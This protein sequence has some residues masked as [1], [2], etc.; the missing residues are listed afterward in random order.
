MAQID[1]RATEIS[2]SPASPPGL[3]TARRLIVLYPA[4]EA[5]P[6]LV[7]RKVRELAF[8]FESQVQLL[9]LSPDELQEPGI[10]RRL[11]TLSEHIEDTRI[12]V[13]TRVEVGR[14]WLKV[15]QPYW[16]DG[17]MIVCFAGT[18]T[19]YK[20][21][22]LRQLFDSKFGASIYVAPD[23]QV[24]T[25]PSTFL[26]SNALAWIGSLALIAGFF[27]LQVRLYP[28]LTGGQYNLLLYASIV[29]ETV[30]LWLINNAS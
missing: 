26:N 30:S 4:F 15:L 2:I 23:F 1:T 13:E 9:G 6:V 11:V 24:G 19:I 17:D 10:R 16:R 8:H 18:D 21:Q 20:D 12:F 7:A 27:W 25:R 29:V 3:Q 22:P 5:N 28:L 14:N